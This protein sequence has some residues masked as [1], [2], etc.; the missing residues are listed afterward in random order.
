MNTTQRYPLSTADGKAIPFDVMKPYGV[1]LRDFSSSAASAAISIPTSIEIMAIEVT[2][3]MIIN[4]GGTAAQPTM[5]V[6]S[7]NSVIIRKNTMKIVS[8]SAAT[9]TVRGLDGDP[10]GLAYIHFISNWAGLSLDVQ[11]RKR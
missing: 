2:Q 6:L 7:S 5:G 1:I 10:A 9:F 11:T 4:F 8:P 3:D